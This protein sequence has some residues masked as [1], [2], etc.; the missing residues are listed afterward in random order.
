MWAH[1]PWIGRWYPRKTK[2]GTELSL[3]SQ[4]CNAVEGNTTFYAEPAA[5]TIERWLGQSPSDFQFAFKLPRTITHEQRLHDVAVPVR[6]FLNTIEPLGERIGPVQVQLPPA[7]SPDGLDLLLSFMRRLP[8]DWPWAIEL[9][10][11]GWFD[12][13]RAHR[14]VDELAIERG[15]GR[16]VLDTRPLYAAPARSEAAVEEKQNKP[17]LPIALDAVGDR[18]LIRVIGEE[19]PEGTLAGLI[20]WVPQLVTWIGQGRTPFVFVHQP[21]NVDSPRLARQLYQAVRDELPELP[22]LPDAPEVAEPEQTSLL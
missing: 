19:T 7:F 5:S 14:M 1:K 3:Y 16:V 9:R 20:A 10:H 2:P 21:E 22:A 17:R 4:L 18:P 15:I 6:S 11:P 8:A 12:G 13:S